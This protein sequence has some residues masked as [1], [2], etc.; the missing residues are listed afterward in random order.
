MLVYP[1][2]DEKGSLCRL[3]SK[4]P[5]S[6]RYIDSYLR[7]FEIQDSHDPRDLCSIIII[8]HIQDLSKIAP[9]SRFAGIRPG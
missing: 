6:L 1:P 7:H 3:K 8:I 5:L 9:R 4:V 2:G